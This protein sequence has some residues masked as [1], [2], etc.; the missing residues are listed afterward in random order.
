MANSVSSAFKSFMSDI[1]NLDTTKTQQG[2]ASRDWLVDDKITRFPINDDDFPILHSDKKIYFGSFSRRTK[3]RELDDIDVMIILS[4]DSCVYYES[5]ETIYIAPREGTDRLNKYLSDDKAYINSRKIIEKF[6]SSLKDVH[7]YSSAVINRRGEAATLK[8]IS[9]EWNFDI[10]PSFITAADDNGVTFY[11]IP[12]GNGNWNKTDPRIDKDRTT[13]INQKHDGKVLNVI[14]AI[15]Y[16]QKKNKLPELKSYLIETI[17][18]N[19]YDN[20]NSISSYLEDEI[21]VALNHLSIAIIGDVSDHKNIQGN[22][23]HLTWDERVAVFSAAL[24]DSTLAKEAKDNE[25]TNTA[26]AFKHWKE[27]FGNDFPDY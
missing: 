27:V 8:L 16:W 15:K 20:T 2:R 18:L 6:K 23:N 19:Y 5:G 7:Q 3:I 14:R 11:L 4:A 9:Y 10:V 24:A 13:A 26:L 21:H 17:L 25:F 12:D 1:V 22:I